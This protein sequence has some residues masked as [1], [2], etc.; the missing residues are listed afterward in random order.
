MRKVYQT[1][2]KNEPIL[3]R[4]LVSP[5]C[6][7]GGSFGGG[8]SQRTLD[9]CYLR[10][11]GQ[12]FRATA[13]SLLFFP[14][15]YS[16]LRN[17]RWNPSNSQH[18]AYQPTPC[19]TSASLFRPIRAGVPQAFHSMFGFRDRRT[20]SPQVQADSFPPKVGRPKIAVA[21]TP[22][23]DSLLSLSGEAG[24]GKTASNSCARVSV[25]WPQKNRKQSRVPRDALK[26]V[27]AVCDR[28]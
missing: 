6:H 23:F 17:R 26:N 22:F 3:S 24:E 1:K 18:V 21:F 5:K 4:R 25:G 2:G 8:G 28:R 27:A 16:K 20:Q 11:S 15:S 14:I 7:E 13:D 9:L 19:A 10:L 12:S